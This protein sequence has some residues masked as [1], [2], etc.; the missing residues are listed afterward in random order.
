[1][2][3]HIIQQ[4]DLEQFS[5][6][7]DEREETKD[8][9][10][11]YY[12]NG[13]AR[14]WA[15]CGK[16]NLPQ[17]EK[18]ET[19]LD[20]AV[21]ELKFES[22]N[23]RRSD[24]SFGRPRNDYNKRENSSYRRNDRSDTSSSGEVA[25][26][27]GSTS[28]ELPPLTKSDLTSGK[29]ASSKSGQIALTWRKSSKT[30]TP[31]P[32]TTQPGTAKPEAPN[33]KIRKLEQLE[34]DVVELSPKFDPHEGSKS[35]AEGSTK[36]DSTPTRTP[37]SESSTTATETSTLASETTP[38]QDGNITKVANIP[39]PFYK[40]MIHPLRGEDGKIAPLIDIGANL[41]KFCYKGRM[42]SILE[43]AKAAGV[44]DI[45]I[46]GTNFTS[47]R[48]AL[49]LCKEWN[50]EVEGVKL[51]A[52]VGVHPMD[53]ASTMSGKFAQRWSY[54]LERLL[55]DEEEGLGEFA[56]AIGEC[57]LDYAG[58]SF[59]A[60]REILAQKQVFRKQ[61]AL[62][63]KYNLPVFAHCRKAHKDFLE[64]VEP[65][66]QL[67]P[68]RLVVH[69]HTDPDVTHLK[70]LVDAGAWIGLTG[71]ITDRREGRFNTD[72]ICE[73][74]WDRLMIETDAPYLLPSNICAIRDIDPK[75]KN[76]P[77]LL[78][79]V[80]EKIAEVSGDVTAAEVAA[81]TRKNAIKFFGLEEETE[82]Q[83]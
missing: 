40:S 19:A 11:N 21:R 28:A 43:R 12:P 83:V 45:L 39:P 58:P 49:R 32:A 74:P 75:W 81:I 33:T 35:T 13:Y 6:R 50:G 78:P 23:I 25:K 73:I 16:K 62:A 51:W 29:T 9:R 22:K 5:L 34:P 44:S 27:N 4:K 69:C 59:N 42:R 10:D 56:V 60:D 46:T 3:V 41:T 61:L 65:W 82:V 63:E 48:A 36:P 15:A 2:P 71:I 14:E 37:M 70:E 7:G 18:R 68:G 1:M 53:A 47:S 26:N 67:H 54:S 76:E 38:T 66:L 52:T 30:M 64:M 80:A 57:G 31:K 24:R 79:F 20:V 77:C 55:N 8:Y 17:P 72:I